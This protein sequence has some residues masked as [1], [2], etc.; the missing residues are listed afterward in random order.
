MF[1]AYLNRSP[2]RTSLTAQL[3]MLRVAMVDQTYHGLHSIFVVFIVF[4][5]V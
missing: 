2:S 4:H 5:G 3:V 1:G